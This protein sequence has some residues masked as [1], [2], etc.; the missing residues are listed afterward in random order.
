MI[1]SFGYYNDTKGVK[2]TPTLFILYVYKK[3]YDACHG[4][5]QI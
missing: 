5:A 3:K 1:Y 4:G 2:T